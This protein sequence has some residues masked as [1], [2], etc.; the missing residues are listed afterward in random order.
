[1]SES[2]N[3]AVL[4]ATADLVLRIEEA[5]R[6]PIAFFMLMALDDAGNP[7]I[8]K[9]F[10]KE[11]FEYFAR[12]KDVIICAPR[13]SGK[14]LVLIYYVLWLIG[15]NPNIRIKWIGENDGL[16]EKRLAMM[17]EVID[18]NLLYHLVFPNVRKTKR[19]SHRPNNASQL[20]LERTLSTPEPTIEARGVLSAAT[21]GRCDVII[22][23]DVV[24]ASNTLMNPALMPKVIQKFNG[25]WMMTLTAKGRVLYI[26]TPWHAN[27]LSAYLRKHTDWAYKKYKHGKPGDP[28]FSIFPERW[29]REILI[30]RRRYFGA[31][32]YARAYLCEPLAE[33]VISVP[34]EALRVY[35][36]A[37]LT[38]EKLL[39]AVAIVSIDPS[40]GKEAHKGKLDYTGIS[41]GLLVPRDPLCDGEAPFELFI[42]V[43]YQLRA[44]LDVQARLA[45]QLVREWE[46]S[47]LLVEAKGMQSL[48]SWLEIE[49]RR[50]L[51]LPAVDITPITFGSLSKGQ[52]LSS[53]IPLLSPPETDRPAVYFHPKAVAENPQAEAI[54]IDGVHYEVNYELR[55]QIL[56]FPLAHDDGLDSCTQLLNWVRSGY[57]EESLATSHE[58][59]RSG[60]SSF[61][62]V[63]L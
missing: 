12:F 31:I 2:S 7:A 25:D 24:G 60:H 13:E 21:G 54:E 30:Q 19:S 44:P 9:D 49:Q 32:H 36:A 28:Y 3:P 52:R 56:S 40:S 18:K 42:V 8:L 16:A 61:S 38:H 6:D 23:D 10:H 5:R 41:V 20:N 46:A 57:A 51:T 48:H 1:M 17:H 45:W 15:K 14:T 55:E 27:D 35:S 47:Y 58:A 63:S 29:P 26:H 43:C 33:G 39:E 37:E 34:P 62:M 4:R 22:A 53:A 50:D 11:W 59:Q